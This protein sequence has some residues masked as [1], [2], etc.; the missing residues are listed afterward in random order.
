MPAPVFTAAG[1]YL[2]SQLEPLDTDPEGTDYALQ[3]FCAALAVPFDQLYDVQNASEIAWSSVMDLA[4]CP[5]WALDWLGQFA[6][7]DATNTADAADKRALIANVGGQRRGTP[8]ALIAAVQPYLTGAKQVILIERD[9]SAYRFIL[10]T[11]ASETPDAAAVLA[12]ALRWK[13]A[14]LVMEHEVVAGQL[15][16]QVEAD[17]ATIGAVEAGYLTVQGVES[18]IPGT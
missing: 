16:A 12:A 7:V 15:I 5:D 6:G 17:F 10:I 4:T 2:Y 9:T 8:Q 11:Y 18:D 1:A 13:P 14:G 3:H